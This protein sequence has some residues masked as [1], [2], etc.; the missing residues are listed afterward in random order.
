MKIGQ[1]AEA[2]HLEEF[3]RGS[4]NAYDEDEEHQGG[5]QHVQCAH[6]WTHQIGKGK[7]FPL[8]FPTPHP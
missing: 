8:S 6:Q 2:I 7:A 4:S 1:D 3:S 5:A